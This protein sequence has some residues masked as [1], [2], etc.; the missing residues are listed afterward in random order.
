MLIICFRITRNRTFVVRGSKIGYFAHDDDD[1]MTYLGKIPEV[2]VSALSLR[3]P[4][5][6]R[7]SATRLHSLVR[8][9]H[10]VHFS[11]S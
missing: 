7:D 2:R 4:V 6:Q 1:Q 8:L 11:N 5:Y 3:A 9:P 10:L